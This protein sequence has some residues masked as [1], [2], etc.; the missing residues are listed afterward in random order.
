M[1]KVIR[2]RER[3]PDI[4]VNLNPFRR[5]NS[6]ADYEPTLTL[7]SGPHVIPSVDVQ[8]PYVAARDAPNVVAADAPNIAA[9]DTPNVAAGDAPNVAAV[10][11]ANVAAVGAAIGKAKDAPYIAIGKAPAI[12]EN[13]IPKDIM[14]KYGL[15]D[16]KMGGR[17]YM[18]VIR[19]VLA[20]R[21]VEP[22]IVVSEGELVV[23]KAKVKRHSNNFKIFNPKRRKAMKAVYKSRAEIKKYKRLIKAE[24]R[25]IKDVTTT[26]W[27]K[28]L[29]N[30]LFK[31]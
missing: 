13:Q 5:R 7:D 2:I 28:R 6:D 23:R 26:S 11:A 14:D 24:H 20:I 9:G 29:W 25:K 31:D 30:Y 27:F 15:F 22:K 12:T 10:G 3:L 8:A 17:K 19:S 16:L 18:R 1:R 21:E 4:N